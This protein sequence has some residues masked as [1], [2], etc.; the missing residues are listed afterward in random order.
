MEHCQDGR[1]CARIAALHREGQDR[2]QLHFYLLQF[3]TLWSFSVS[4]WEIRA[5]LLL[6]V[7]V[8]VTVLGTLIYLIWG[9]SENC[10]IHCNSEPTL[11]LDR[12]DGVIAILVFIIIALVWWG[13]TLQWKLTHHRDQN[14]QTSS[15]YYYRNRSSSSSSSNEE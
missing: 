14:R 4:P 12:D 1:E 5:G 2:Y 6:L 15:D 13:L 3:F 7:T 11:T 9:H 8:L 10:C